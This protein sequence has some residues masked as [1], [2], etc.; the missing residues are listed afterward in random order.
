MDTANRR[1]L[2]AGNWKMH[3][4]ASGAAALA[5]EVLQRTG[6]FRHA[7]VC[8]LPAFPLI[9]AVARVLEGSPVGFGAQDLSAEEEGAF[10]GEVS[11][12]MLT[13]LGCQYVCIGHSE[14]REYHLESDELVRRKV[15]R[16]LS[17]GLIPI[18][19]V[20]EK[21]AERDRGETFARVERQVTVGLSDLDAKAME[22]LVI[23]YEPVWAIGTGRNATP[24]QAQEVHEFLRGLLARFHGPEVAARTRILYGGSVKPGNARELLAQRDVDGAL[25]GGASLSGESFA[26]I[27]ESAG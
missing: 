22:R 23:A 25:V 9:P 14:R 1:P 27:V 16:A 8:V 13:S 20:G 21:L 15:E 24:A 17:A 2:I 3:L 26:A 6:R 18:V 11:A 10:T 5:R 7:D 12:R 19:C 4:D